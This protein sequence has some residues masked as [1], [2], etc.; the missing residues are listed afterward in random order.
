MSIDQFRLDDR[1][2]IVTGAGRGLGRAHAILL[3]SLGAK[4]VVNDF[5]GSKEGVG[6]DT[7][8]AN[9]VVAEIIAD[10]GIAVADT[11]SVSTPEGC[12]AIVDTAIREFGRLD[13]LVNNA[14]ISRWASFPE[15]D[16][17]NL[18]VTLDVHL[19]GTWHMTRSA[20]PHFE[21]QEYGRIINT[22]STG[23]LGLP[24]NLAYAT[25]KG[26]VLGFTRSLAYQARSTPGILVNAVSPNAMTRPSETTDK[27]GVVSGQVT[28]ARLA[29][30][31][32]NTVS[33]LVGYLAQESCPVN[34]EII[35]AGAGRFGRWFQGFTNGWL[36]ES[37]EPASVESIASH[38]EEINDMEDF[39]V[40]TDLYDWSARFMSQLN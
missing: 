14:G 1:V 18:E 36:N 40:P 31:Q 35:V 29:A 9:E 16:A 22:V 34:G 19:R 17:E 28:D 26:A 8:P 20:W 7:Q 25:A 2:A 15:A 4:V 23:M 13:I 32:T 21:K 37:A 3:A 24:S 38:W 39:Y 12:A 33:P 10:G 5:G 6:S 11:N 30:M 27:A